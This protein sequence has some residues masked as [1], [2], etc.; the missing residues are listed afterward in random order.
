MGM[1]EDQNCA[2]RWTRWTP[3]RGGGKSTSFAGWSSADDGDGDDD[4]D[5]DDDD[6]NDDDED[7]DEDDDDDDDDGDDD[8]DDDDEGSVV[9]AIGFA[10]RT[11]MPPPPPTSTR[12]GERAPRRGSGMANAAREDGTTA[13]A[14]KRRTRGRRDVTAKAGAD[15]R[16]AIAVFRSIVVVLQ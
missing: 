13:T 7:E 12:W 11:A 8:G 5:D 2:A 4:D 10:S 3:V 9:V 14:T 15:R 16:V 6:D 1:A